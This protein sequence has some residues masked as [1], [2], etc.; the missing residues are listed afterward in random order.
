MHFSIIFSLYI[1]Y[2]GFLSSEPLETYWEIKLAQ[3]PLQVEWENQDNVWKG[4]WWPLSLINQKSQVGNDPRKKWQILWLKEHAFK[5]N[6]YHF[7]LS[8]I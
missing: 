6:I 4:K 5:V 3:L 8:F 7:F 2:L 1:Q